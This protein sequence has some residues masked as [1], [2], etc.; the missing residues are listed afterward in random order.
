[1]SHPTSRPQSG[2][3]RWW[4][5]GLRRDLVIGTLD[6]IGYSVMVGCGE[7][8]LGA[9]VLALGLGPVVA[10]LVASVPLLVGAVVQCV[11]PLAVR[12]LGG[13]RRFVVL[14]AA[15]QAAALVPL[16]WWAVAGHAAPW[17]LIA[18]AS[19]YWSAGMA[20]APPP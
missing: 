20:S 16:A 5:S 18:A 3:L 17:Q 8:Y 12:R 2:P 1:M 19:L 4:R 9:F 7:M 11:A 15:I 6:A 13:R 14:C 10:G